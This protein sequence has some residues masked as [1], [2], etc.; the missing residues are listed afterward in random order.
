MPSEAAAIGARARLAA[1][2][3]RQLQ[4]VD[5]E[6]A[7]DV[8]HMARPERDARRARRERALRSARART[9]YRFISLRAL[10]AL[11]G[12][13]PGAGPLPPR[14][15]FLRPSRESAAGS[16]SRSAVAIDGDKRQVG[17]ARHPPVPGQDLLREH[18]DFHFER[19]APRRRDARLEDDQIADLD[20]MQELQAV[21]RRGDERGFAYADGRRWLRRCR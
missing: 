17:A 5:P 2:R 13:P 8:A 15:A 18:F 4:Q 3:Q 16:C 9:R 6:A 14:A 21:D 7:R 19:R 20:R 12:V 10:C 1:N 11:R